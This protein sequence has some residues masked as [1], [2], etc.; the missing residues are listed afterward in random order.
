MDITLTK[1]IF[2]KEL[3]IFLKAKMYDETVQSASETHKI[4]A[5]NEVKIADKM[6]KSYL[7]YQSDVTW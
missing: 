3:Q 4:T 2:Y 1:H 6:H 7:G 5:R